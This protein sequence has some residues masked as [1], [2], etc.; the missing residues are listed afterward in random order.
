VQAAQ[1]TL[2]LSAC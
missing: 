2:N 1:E